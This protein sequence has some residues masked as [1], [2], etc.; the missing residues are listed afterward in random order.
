MAESCRPVRL[1]GAV[2][3]REIVGGRNEK[4]KLQAS[5]MFFRILLKMKEKNHRRSMLVVDLPE[6]CQEFRQRF[7]AMMDRDGL[8]FPGWLKARHKAVPEGQVRKAA[9]PGGGLVV[10]G[11]G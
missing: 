8:P 11:L 6:V 1:S 3:D 4:S 7:W 2:F 9:S 10:D 5:A